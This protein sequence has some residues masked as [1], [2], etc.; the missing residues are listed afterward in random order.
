MSKPRFLESEFDQY[1]AELARFH[2]VPV[3]WEDTVSYGTG[4]AAGPAAVLAASNQLE[5][6]DG[7]SSPAEEGIHTWPA[8][9]CSGDPA[10]VHERIATAVRTAVTA[11]RDAHGV[12]I[13]LGGEHSI[14]APA[15][16]GYL[17]TTKEP[18]GI[19]QIDAHADL[20]D[21]YE[22]RSDSHA[23]VA[24]RMHADHRLPIVQIGIRATSPEEHLY[25]EMHRTTA[26]TITV[27]YARD[28]VP[29]AVTEITLPPDFPSRVWLT[30]DVDGLD[31]AVIP[32]TGT[33]VPGG[34]AWYQALSIVESIARQRTI[35]GADIVEL[36]PIAT[37]PASDYAA[38]ELTYRIM[39]I[40]ARNADQY[41]T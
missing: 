22:G 24:R 27:H 14:T 35:I 8:V 31:P 25:I 23:S 1:P 26:P 20:R 33:P 21:S 40:I 30:F 16:H 17:S 19:V 37:L 11:P 39:G 18:V 12:P 6:W 4:T 5:V 34:L 2:V 32:A 29:A 41:S 10:T 28:I 38:A 9:D 36:A 7:I 15:V 3:P 13:V